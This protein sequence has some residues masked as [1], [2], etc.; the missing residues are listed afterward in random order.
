MITVITG[1]MFSS[2][3]ERLIRILA[4]GERSNC[5]VMAFKPER[6]TRNKGIFS[7]SGSAFP[8][9]SIDDKKLEEM[10]YYPSKAF[11]TSKPLIVGIDEVQFCDPTA[12]F[13]ISNYFIHRKE[14]LVLCGLSFDSE[15]MPFGPLSQMERRYRTGDLTYRRMEA[16]CS[17]CGADGATE[18]FC[19]VKKT[20]QVLVGRED[21]EARHIDCW[22]FG[23]NNYDRC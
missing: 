19:K 14:W 2:K 20:E 18:T 12:I 17:F 8:A 7:Y 11:A 4:N 6:D 3:S 13:E 9:T 1:P 16:R 21:F 5:E 23:V 15:G 10:A 22:L